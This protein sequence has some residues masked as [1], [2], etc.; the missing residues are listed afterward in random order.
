[1]LNICAYAFSQSSI[2]ISPVEDN[3]GGRF[4]ATD[5]TTYT[6]NIEKN[7][8]TYFRFTQSTLAKNGFITVTSTTYGLSANQLPARIFYKLC[9][10]SDPTACSLNSTE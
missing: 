7:S 8:S 10:S 5:K 2:K 4:D 1:M 9:K 3:A 6:F